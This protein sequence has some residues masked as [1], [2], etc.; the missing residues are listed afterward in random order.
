MKL[1]RKT[2]ANNF[3]VSHACHEK[4]LLVGFRIV[5]DAVRHFLVGKTRNDLTR[6]RVPLFD[7]SVV[8]GGKELVAFIVEAYVAYCLSVTEVGS[9]AATIFVHFPNL[10]RER[11]RIRTFVFPVKFSV[12]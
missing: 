3:L 12:L 1:W 7:V 4:V 11:E 9:H 8:G 10:E 2:Y 5:L 6:F